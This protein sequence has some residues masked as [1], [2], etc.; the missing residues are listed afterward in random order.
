MARY[1][2]ILLTFL[3]LGYSQSQLPDQLFKDGNQ[4]VANEEFRKAADFYE[5]IIARGYHHKNLYYNLGNTYYRL[6]YNGL[7]IWAYE[8]GLQYD[9][10]DDDLKYN[11]SIANAQVRDRIQVPE[12]LFVVEWYRWLKKNYSMNQWLLFGI[13]CFLLSAIIFN[14]LRLVA[15]S[16]VGRSSVTVLIILGVLSHGI[17]LDQYW[18]VTETSEAIIVDT[19]VFAYSAPFERSDLMLFKIHEGIKVEIVQAQEEWMEIILLDGKQGWIRSDT[20]RKL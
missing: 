3:A 9:P 15:H 16:N 11:L 13:G 10:Q 1:S 18:D 19:E 5:E 6:G 20:V 17:A 8:K 7:A 12:T 4:A 2:L 14:F